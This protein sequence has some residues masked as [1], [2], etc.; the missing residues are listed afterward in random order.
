MEGIARFGPTGGNITPVSIALPGAACINVAGL[1]LQGLPTRSLGGRTDTDDA[2]F[3]ACENLRNVTVRGGSVS[4]APASGRWAQSTDA[5]FRLGRSENL[6]ISDGVRLARGPLYQELKGDRAVSPTNKGQYRPR[7]AR[8][9]LGT[10]IMVWEDYRSGSDLDIYARFFYSDFT[11]GPEIAVC[12]A[13]GHQHSPAITSDALGNFYVLWQ[14]ERNG[15][16]DIFGRRYDRWGSPVGEEFVVCTTEGEQEK[17]SVTAG[18][19]GTL[20]AAWEDSRSGKT[21]GIRARLL[22]YTGAPLKDE[23][24]FSNELFD[25]KSPSV[26]TVAG[27]FAMVWENW[28]NST[29][30]DIDGVMLDGAA[31]PL[32]SPFTICNAHGNQ[33]SPAAAALGDGRW[34]VVWEDTRG[35]CGSDIKARRLEADGSAAGPEEPICTAPGDQLRPSISTDEL[36]GAV[37][38]WEDR[39]SGGADVYFKRL[40]LTFETIGTEALASAEKWSEESPAC[41]LLPSGNITIA[42]SDWRAVPP[43]L[44]MKLLGEPIYAYT[45]GELT[46][47][48]IPCFAATYGSVCLCITLPHAGRSPFNTTGFE[49]DVL[50]GQEGYVLQSGLKTGDHVMVDPGVHE[51]IR[52]R[53]RLW[54]KDGNIT[55]VLHA[56]S[57]GTSIDETF[58]VP[59][60]GTFSGTRV[61]DGE[62][63]LEDDGVLKAL[64][65]DVAVKSGETDSYQVAVAKLQDGSGDYVAVWQEG[66]GPS[67]DIMARR[68]SSSGEPVSAE[69]PVCTAPG[70]QEEPSVAVDLNG[71]IIVVWADNRSG[72][73]R[74][75]YCRRFDPYGVPLGVELLVCGTAGDQTSPEV[76]TDLQN[77]FVIVW[78]DHSQ[79][80]SSI[81]IA[82]YTPDCKLL[83][84]ATE[85]AWTQHNILQPAL[86]TDGYNRIIV[87]WADYRA[88][89][90]GNYDIYAAILDPECEPVPGGREIAVCTRPGAQFS[91]ALAVD[92]TGSFIVAYADAMNPLDANVLARRFDRSGSPVTGELVISS[93]PGDQGEPSVVFD[94]DGNFIAVWHSLGDGF[95]V[96]GRHFGPSGAPLGPEFVVCNVKNVEGEPADQMHPVIAGGPENEFVVAWVDNRPKYDMDIWAKTYGFPG[97]VT[98]GT[99]LSPAYDLVHTPLSLDNAGWQASLPPGTS[100]SVSIRTGPDGSRWSDWEPVPASSGPLSTPPARFVQWALV[101]STAE[102]TF[103]PSVESFFVRY[104]TY[105]TNGSLTSPPLNLTFSV[106]EVAVSWRASLNGGGLVV[107]ASVDD[108]ATWMSSNNGAPASVRG[109]SPRPVL[110][111]RVFMYSNG[112]SSPVLEEVNISWLLESCPLDPWLD[113]GGDG[114]R[115]WSFEGRFNQTVRLN[116]LEDVLNGL[117]A[118]SGATGTVLLP[119]VLHSS[120]AGLIKVF[121]LVINLN[122]PPEIL[123]WSPEAGELEIIEGERVSFWVEARDRDGDALSYVWSVNGRPLG[124]RGDFLFT[125]DFSSRGTYEIR[126]EVSDGPSAVNRT[127]TVR[128]LNLNR[129]P[130][131]NWFPEGRVVINETESATFWVVVADPDGDNISVVWLLDGSVV[132]SGAV[133]EYST[134][135]ESSGE[136]KVSV[137]VSDGEA[138]VGHNWSVTVLNRNRPPGIVSCIPERA[139]EVRLRRG[140]TAS[141]S[142][143]AVDPDGDELRFAWKINGRTVQGEDRPVF[144]CGRGL[145]PGVYTVSVEVSD[146]LASVY[147][148]W[149]LRVVPGGGAA[150]GA[151]APALLLAAAGGLALVAVALVALLRTRQRQRGPDTRP[152]RSER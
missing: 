36:L 38:A 66:S 53:I 1:S 129:P 24:S 57:L 56:W 117:L 9:P 16:F 98:S 58:D 37:V 115:E 43:E 136:H 146:G 89:T 125:T 121:D 126:A 8:G 30:V 104:T 110:R 45:S 34:M 145:E 21:Y 80:Y 147:G 127:W 48:E 122:T 143:E 68:F 93:Q 92:G 28:T 107:E 111:Y 119:V 26:C 64:G 85:V 88:G 5:E 84:S 2:D 120:A 40:T 106:D 132:Y 27:G 78:T 90:G 91:P 112:S 140:A 94:D 96:L 137:L 130:E 46:G 41:L 131:L 23:I 33:S 44:H 7:I 124:K 118:A 116:R 108:G 11:S 142:V 141:F 114:S 61:R 144:V 102:K 134:G 135:Y 81:Y 100:V 60:G 49:L 87:A 50:D 82:K 63:E 70:L 73:D 4:L 97:H 29:G 47:P 105:A 79:A 65:G 139:V 35:G 75:I 18:P 14:D 86:A 32:T 77:S 59:N 99:Y 51:S 101:L 42:W 149:S 55:P 20:L 133:Y 17:P 67:A 39:R 62:L 109:L 95:D 113:I 138:V 12:N 15:D 72:R 150:T 31:V 52:L 103:T 69:I 25:L 123:S 3:L 74:D 13:R 54:T 71:V 151:G 152:R 148:H 76:A 22:D 6:N 83:H 128:V 10:F 19:G